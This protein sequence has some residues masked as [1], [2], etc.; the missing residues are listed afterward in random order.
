VQLPI[1]ISIDRQPP[2]ARLLC[3]GNIVALTLGSRGRLGIERRDGTRDEVDVDTR[4][5][6]FTSLIVLR[7]RVGNGSESLALPRSSLGNEAHRQLR[8]WLKWR[9]SA[10]V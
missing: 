8:V 2:L 4:S 7:F 9:A 5:T 10:S 1:T 3:R 6:V